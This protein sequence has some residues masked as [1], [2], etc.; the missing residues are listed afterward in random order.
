MDIK[1][2]KNLGAAEKQRLLSRSETDI[3]EAADTVRPIIDAV[4]NRGDEALREYTLKFD[5]AD[6]RAMPLAARAEDYEEA[7]KSLSQEVKEALEYAIDNVIAFHDFQRPGPMSF[8]EIRPGLFAGERPLPIPSAGLYVPRGRGSFPSM[9]YM[10][11]VPALVAGVKQIRI[12]TPPNPDGSI[13]A[14]C[15]YA[16]KILSSWAAAR[17]GAESALEVFRVGGAQAVAALAYGTETLGRVVKIVG[18]GSRYV[19]AAKRLLA[20]VIDTGLPAGPSE[21]IVLADGTTDPRLVAADLLI[22]AEHGS[23]SSALLVT[24]DEK[25]ARAAADILPRLIAELPEPRRTFAGDVFSGYGGLILAQ[26]MREAAFIVNS[27]APE[28]LQIHSA[29]PL[30]LLPFITNAGEILLGETTPFSLANYACGANAVLPTGGKAVSFSAVS[31]RDFIKYSSVVHVTREGFSR[32]QGRV[33]TL[34]EYEG[35]T[36]HAQALKKRGPDGGFAG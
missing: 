24:P 14:A 9:L 19:T 16:A 25:T 35:F 34:A 11:A 28:H 23:D 27:F 8:A 4:K 26:D 10:L 5:G 20:P 29:R 18:P 32:L 31:A 30:E 3:G 21:S 15:L 33:S 13:D 7:E 12:V 17:G 1:I 22:E 6:L 2:W 36:A